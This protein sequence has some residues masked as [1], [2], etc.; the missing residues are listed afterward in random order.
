MKLGRLRRAIGLA[1][2][3]LLCGVSTATPALAQGFDFSGFVASELR[4]FPDDPQFPEQDDSHVSPSLVVQPEFRYRWN[5]R[6]DRLTFIP[7]VRLDPT[8]RTA[9]TSMSGG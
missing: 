4:A 1:A 9:P 7:F 6:D 8:T 5:R 3:G 2:T